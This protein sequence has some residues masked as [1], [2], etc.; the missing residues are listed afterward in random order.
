MHSK[1]RHKLN[2]V[3]VIRPVFRAGGGEGSG[4]PTIRPSDKNI[5]SEKNMLKNFIDFGTLKKFLVFF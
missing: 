3:S 5:F 2:N 1:S 4:P